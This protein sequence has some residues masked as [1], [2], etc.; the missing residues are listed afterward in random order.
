MTQLGKY[1]S[2]MV[3]IDATLPPRIGFK[4]TGNHRKTPVF[5]GVNHG[6]TMGKPV[7]MFPSTNPVS[8][9]M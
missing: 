4:G 5:H 6:K 2:T 9:I 1:S 7:Q 3:R 8:G